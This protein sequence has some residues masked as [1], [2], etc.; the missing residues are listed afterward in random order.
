MLYQQDQAL[1]S[2]PEEIRQRFYQNGS[3]EGNFH[4]AYIG[5]IVSA[6]IIRE[7]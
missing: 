2:I 1:N 6:Y 5:Q 3:D 4:T 7:D